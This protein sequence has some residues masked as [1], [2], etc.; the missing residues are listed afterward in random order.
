MNAFG[1]LICS[2]ISMFL[3]TL[4]VDRIPNLDLMTNTWLALITLAVFYTSVPYLLYFIIL[5]RSGPGNLML[6]TLLIPP[7]AV[8][9]GVFALGKSIKATSLIGFALIALGLVV[10]DGRITLSHKKL[11]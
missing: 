6:V 8:T 1:M 4:W 10:V 11:T 5:K 7:V 2:R 9:L 3:I